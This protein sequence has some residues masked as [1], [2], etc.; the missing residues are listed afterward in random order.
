MSDTGPGPGLGGVM[1]WM[2]RDEYFLFGLY[3]QLQLEGL[4]V[5][6]EYWRSPHQATRDR[7]RVIV[8]SDTVAVNP[9]QAQRFWNGVGFPAE[10]DVNTEAEYTVQTFWARVGYEIS[11]GDAGYLTPY[12]HVDYYENPESIADET[13]GGNEAGLSDDGWFLRL[14]AGFVYRPIQPVAFKAEYNPHIQIIDAA[15]DFGSEVRFSLSYF[16]ELE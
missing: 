8:L 12:A 7:A 15:T 10:S 5:Q 2:E 3:A 11:L 14:A 6:L 1:N 4:I 13:R 9:R 16:W